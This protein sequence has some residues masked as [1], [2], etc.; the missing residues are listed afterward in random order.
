MLT[1]PALPPPSMDPP[2]WYGPAVATFEAEVAGNPYDPEENDVRV[3]FVG[4]N[5]RQ[6]ERLAFIDG[7]ST[8]KSIL[9]APEPGA[10]RAILRR[11][12]EPLR[13]VPE[14][15]V[16]D[17]K[18][19]LPRGFLRLDRAHPNRFVWDNG[20]PYYP[21]GVNLGWQLGGI[22]S[23]AEQI[24]KLSK[25]GVTWTR[26]WASNWDGKNPFWPTGESS[27]PPDRLWEP[28]F[29]RWNGIFATCE[30]SGV[31]LQMVLH[32]HGSWSSVV[33]PD[34]PHHPWNEARGGFLRRASDFFTHREARRRT[35]MWL[36]HAVARYAH[37]PSLFAWELFNEVE[38]T[39]AGLARRA[40]RIVAWHEE[41]AGYIRSLDPYGHPVTTSAMRAPSGV[42]QTVD[43][44]QA[45]VYADR[46]GPAIERVAPPRGKPVFVGEFGHGK[47]GLFEPR[48][49][50]RE[51]LLAGML[52]N[53][54]APPMYWYW[55]L[56]EKDDL[57]REFEIVAEV[58]RRSE[59]ARHPEA[60]PRE[61]LVWPGAVARALGERGWM[62]VRITPRGAG[63]HR[64]AATGLDDGQY[65][66]TR[67]DLT[68]GAVTTD[69]TMVQRAAFGVELSSTDIVVVLARRPD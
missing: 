14:Q 42:W 17:L 10:Y 8:W 39:D 18:E 37:S 9:V 24:E 50:L 6:Y 54:A 35:K 51:G 12:G 32:N 43:F 45:H 27:T 19:R 44:A 23:M 56:V 21:L 38:F 62:T 22:S 16:L 41:M 30:K 68:T 11:N 60:R 48:K 47:L 65:D 49:I 13:A 63:F 31:A 15:V 52:Q 57:Y 55:D 28:A 5:G 69:T 58:I 33:N 61:V 66:R 67:I 36:R 3:L 34:W 4:E 20:E 2:A 59:I 46:I 1:A 53:H 64:V 26:I 29:A 40:S 7:R 25:S